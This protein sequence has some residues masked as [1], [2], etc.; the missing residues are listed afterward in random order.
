MSALHE[1]LT[2]YV[3]VRRALG[4][5][6]LE[7][8]AALG[9]F[10]DLVEGSGSEFITIELSMRWATQSPLVQRA[11][12]SRRL[13]QVRGFAKWLSA[14][15]P[16]TEVPPQRLLN[17]GHRR[18]RPYI[19]TDE[20]VGKLM[21]RAA[22]LPSFSGLR[23]HTYVTLI[24]LLAATG[25]RPGEAIDLNKSDVELQ[26]GVLSVR[27][28]KHG[29]SRFVPVQAC[30][31]KALR[32]YA[33]LRDE[34][35][36]SHQDKAFLVSERGRRLKGCSARRTFAKISRAIGI[37]K[38][39]PGPGIGW[40]PRLQD[41][42]HTFATKRIIEWYRAGLDAHRE[43]PKLS[44]YLGHSR[45]ADTYWYIQAV[46]ELL[47]LATERLEHGSNR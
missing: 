24:G 23:A 39:L 14:V 3:A 19:Y 5:K 40:G 43:L 4:S 8:A 16:R 9:Q 21:D 20:E 22:L 45:T 28:S 26:T 2:Q 31:Q 33:R 30:V 34:R 42:R 15:D 18:N 11:T 36:P 37:R 47:R 13:T 35:G 44:T 27:S 25:L 46:P 10:I 17:V 38:T 32:N 41:F 6:F 12:W 1:S 29:K 7:P